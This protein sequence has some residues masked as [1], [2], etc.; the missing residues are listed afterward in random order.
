MHLLLILCHFLIESLLAFPRIM[1]V[2]EEKSFRTG[3]SNG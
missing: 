1:I 2:N 3:G